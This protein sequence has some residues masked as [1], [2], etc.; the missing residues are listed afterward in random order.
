[1]HKLFSVLSLFICLALL[2]ACGG[3]SSAPTAIPAPTS[4][5]ATTTSGAAVALATA[6]GGAAAATAVMTTTAVMTGAMGTPTMAMT[7]TA[8]IAATAGPTMAMTSTAVTTPA[9]TGT[10]GTTSSACTAPTKIV[11]A[12]GF[13]PS[14]SD[15]PFYVAAAKGYY[16]AACLDVSFNYSQIANIY[17]LLSDGQQ[18]QF[19]SASG[20][21]I[22]PARLKGANITYVMALFQKYP[23]GALA[24]TSGGFTLKTPADLKGHSIGYSAAGSPTYVGMEA[25][26][27][28]GGL[29]DKDVTE[30]QIGFNE[31]EALSS[32]R[33][34]IAFT[35]ISN[36]AVQMRALGYKVQTLQLPS[37]GSLISSG[38][39]VGDTLM[40]QHPEIVQAFISATQHGLQDTL[41]DPSGAFDI[42][43]KQL[44]ISPDKVAVQRDVMTATLDYE[45]PPSGH[46]L[47]WSDPAGWQASQDLL[48]S[49]NLITITADPTTF[50][51][52]KFVEATKPLC[53]WRQGM[54]VPSCRCEV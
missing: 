54:I 33:V 30:T 25:M 15:A 39:A 20:D 11:M 36:E 35:F 34:D 48:K 9:I 10:A 28:A 40:Q 21:A 47:G 26:L 12:T 37:S 7:A 43:L 24:L 32:K 18:I 5:S 31:V 41:S 49:L 6:T 53:R 3:N 51:T 52:N 38:I 14:V 46:P 22:I 8:A 27:K 50:Y 17:Q 45:Q 1:M 44:T 13:T 4:A 29:T 42:S 2:A 19:A 23:V 16:T